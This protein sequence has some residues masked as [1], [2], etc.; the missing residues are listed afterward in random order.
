MNLPE[1]PA[2]APPVRL[3]LV[4]S[5]LFFVLA[6]VLPPPGAG[7]QVVVAGPDG[8]PSTSTAT[9]WRSCDALDY[10]GPRSSWLE[11]RLQASCRKL[12]ADGGTSLEDALLRNIPRGLFVMLPIVAALMLPL[13]WR[14]RRYYVEH[15]LFLVHNHS[16]AFLGFTLLLLLGAWPRA[17]SVVEWL[18]PLFAVYFAGYCY[19]GMRVVYGQ[20]RRRTLAKFTAVV[21]LY[22][23]VGVLT[24]GLTT[25]VTVATL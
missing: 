19:R 2:D 4:I 17:A 13:Y 7:V 16:F 5:V 3:H 10:S 25:M 8:K 11:P 14:P 23:V 22:V 24:L 15:L 9:D 1:P 21:A 18:W 12:I 20:S 6:G